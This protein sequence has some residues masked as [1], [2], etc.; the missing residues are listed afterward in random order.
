MI[1]L[2]ANFLINFYV[3][4][5]EE[6][7]RAEELLKSFSD[8]EILISKLVIVEVI[9]VMNVKLKQDPYLVSK[10][11]KELNDNYN[12][13]IDN[14]F[15]DKGFGILTREMGENKKRVSLFDCIYM[16]LM[17]ELGIKKI[18]TFDNHFD[19]IDGIVK[20]C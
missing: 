2:D 7:E 14:D 17:R 16:A 18:A 15:Y 11:Y 6:H 19:N 13:I 3:K 4:T 8:D 12:V 10:V 1:F 20:V 9:T 5:N